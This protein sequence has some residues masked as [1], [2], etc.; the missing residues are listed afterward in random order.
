MT[1]Q[2]LTILKVCLL[3]LL[4]LFFLRVLRAVWRELADPQLATA[5][6]PSASAASIAS[7]ASEPRRATKKRPT[8]LLVAEPE[9]LAG[10]RY[11][12][13][14]TLTFGRSTAC[15][16]AIEDSFLSHT[17]ARVVDNG[18]GWAAEDLASTNGTYVNRRRITEPV[19]LRKG[20]HLQMGTLVM[21]VV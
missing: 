3:I 11:P 13:D 16:V 9:D 10:T 5:G 7:K 15:S 17:H 20:D 6:P 21:E 2:L 8:A 1:D 4:Y 19:M 14:R 18:S 12:L